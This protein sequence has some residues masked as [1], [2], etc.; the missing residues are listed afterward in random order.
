MGMYGGNA[1]ILL[2]EMTAHRDVGGSWRSPLVT[3]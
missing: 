2:M 3:V 1:V